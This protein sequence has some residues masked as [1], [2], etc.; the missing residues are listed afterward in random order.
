MYRVYQA[1]D[2]VVKQDCARKAQAAVRNAFGQRTM[3]PTYKSAARMNKDAGFKAKRIV[4]EVRRS[5]LLPQH[6]PCCL[7]DFF[8]LTCG[9]MLMYWRKNEKEELVARKKAEKQAVDRAKAEEEARES[10]RQARKLNFL[11]TQTELYSH[12]IGKKIKTAEAED[13]EAEMNAEGN[14]EP[15]LDEG[16][17]AL[18][19]IDYD[20]GECPLHGPPHMGRLAYRL[21]SSRRRGELAETC[22]TRSSSCGPG[23]EGQ[24]EGFRR[25]R[26]R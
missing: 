7:V 22:C 4:K 20:D 17:E 10:K 26:R 5:L 14:E 24:S 18:P 19:D 2:T 25:F 12:F 16:G 23:S 3:K 1:F 21:I 9:Q 8:R 11:L 13:M 6:F 15:G